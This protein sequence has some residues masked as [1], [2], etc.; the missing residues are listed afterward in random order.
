MAC[1]KQTI[2]NARIG[3]KTDKLLNRLPTSFL[4]THTAT[5][6]IIGVLGLVYINQGRKHI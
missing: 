2:V 5:R 6:S 1:Y 3:S 4:A